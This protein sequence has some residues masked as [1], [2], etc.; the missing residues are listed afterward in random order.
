M[1]TYEKRGP[2]FIVKQTSKLPNRCPK[3]RG[4]VSHGGVRMGMSAPDISSC[5]K[6]Q[7]VTTIL[8]LATQTDPPGGKNR[9]KKPLLTGASDYSWIVCLT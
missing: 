7:R 2:P 4:Y 1:R 8:F 5:E 6:A 9:M 3:C